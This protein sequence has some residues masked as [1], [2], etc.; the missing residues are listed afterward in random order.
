MG[1]LRLLLDIVLSLPVEYWA[2]FR[3]DVR[4]RWRGLAALPGFTAV[5]VTSLSLGIGIATCAYSE[6]NGLLHDLPGAT[7][8]DELIAVQAP[9]SY[10]AYKRYNELRDLFSSTFAYVA[11]V[12]F[13]ISTSGPAERTWGQLV[14]TGY[15]STLGV[16]PWLGRFFDQQDDKPGQ[17]P[18]VVVSYRYWEDRLGSDRSAIGKTVRINGHP[19][20]I[21]GVGP[22]GFAGASPVLFPS[23]VWMPVTAGANVAPEL[24]NGALQRRD[25]PMFQ[26]VGRLRPGI[27]EPAAQAELNNAAQQ[28]SQSYGEADRN[29]KGQRIVLLAGGKTLPLRK[30][31]APFFRE[32]LFFLGGLLLVIA[33]ANVANMMLAR[34]TDR[35]KEIA[36][37]LA[38]G[39]SRGRLIQQ[40]LTESLLLASGGAVPAFLFAVWAMHLFSK[41]KMPI[42]IPVAL[43]LNPDWRALLFTFGVTI[44]TGIVFG[45]APAFRATR[46]DLVPALKEDGEVRL[47]RQSRLSP[48][49]LLVL[50]QMAASLT[51]LLI[52]G[53]L[54]Y[55]IQSTLGVQEGFNAKN[56][57]LISIDPVRDGYSA[58]R[59]SAFFEKLL[60][61]VRSL[62]SVTAAAACLTDT[63]PVALDGNPGVRF[64]SPGKVPAGVRDAHWARRHIVGHEYFE[65]AGI[66]VL[67]GR[68]FRKQD[69]SDTS[70][71]IVVSHEA[72]RRFWNGGNPVGRRIELGNGEASGGFGAMPGTI[73]YRSSVLTKGI[74]SF[75]V[76]GVVGDVSEDLVASKKHPAVYFPLRPSDYAQPSLRG[77]TL[78]LRAVPGADV[79]S[80]VRAEIA[81]IDSDI[82][83][84]NARSMVEHI[85]Q[86]MSALQSASWTYG[87]MG[88]CGLVLA[89]VGLAGVTAHSVSKRSHEIGIRMA[90]GAR[91]CDVLGLVMKEGSILVVA[92]TLIGLTLALLGIRALSGIFFTVASVQGYDPILFV[93]A[94]VLLAGLALVACYIPARRSTRIDPIVTLRM[95]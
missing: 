6:V 44:V 75:E 1:L 18:I 84:F 87:L 63:L 52:I 20:T 29:Q 37:R 41:L 67:A 12:P 57:Y 65:T 91:T 24:E 48:R 43:N 5:A 3:R 64:D 17:A 70:N 73:D 32:F 95:E 14:T 79:L 77:V 76:V 47:G 23:D 88:F 10:P 72:V 21:A 69:E 4:H 83:P 34:A 22:E 25:L 94:P 7:N 35:R 49:N 93:G 36:V 85:A 54:G 92:G 27:P 46:T 59:A 56:L 33:C 55:G 8:P 40:L 61:R 62:P 13:G 78:M 30:Q 16:R 45:L 28:F 86:F 53:Y 50:G 89:S 19:A 31:D 42:P 82:A 74:R 66:P 38:V 51:L 58:P 15:F 39:A 71:T 26:M 80:A 9:I 68:G 90:L 81:A 11:P 2:E 60:Q